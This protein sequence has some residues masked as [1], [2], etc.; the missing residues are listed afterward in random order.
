[1]GHLPLLLIVGVAVQIQQV[2]YVQVRR[3]L[4]RELPRCELD[5]TNPVYNGKDFENKRCIFLIFKL[6][7]L[8]YS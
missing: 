2:L 7:M 1:V 5:W 3:L 4:V 6:V 8:A